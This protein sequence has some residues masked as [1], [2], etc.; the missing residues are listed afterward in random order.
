M[1]YSIDSIGYYDAGGV[2]SKSVAADEAKEYITI[3]DGI[4]RIKDGRFYSDTQHIIKVKATSIYHDGSKDAADEI[5]A[6]D[7]HHFLHRVFDSLRIG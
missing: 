1:I 6:G 3:K 2:F 4:L 5:S 7:Q